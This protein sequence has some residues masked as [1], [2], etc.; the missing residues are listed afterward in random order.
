VLLF[1]PLLPVPQPA[2]S[3]KTQAQAP[4][5]RKKL[6]EHRRTLLRFPESRSIA[7]IIGD[8]VLHP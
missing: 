8:D 4:I 7:L 6:V 3:D 1:A 5:R 2:A